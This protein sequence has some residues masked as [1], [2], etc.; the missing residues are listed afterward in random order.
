[1]TDPATDEVDL[2]ESPDSEEVLAARLSLYGA[3]VDDPQ[4]LGTFT[5]EELVGLDD[6]GRPPSAPSPWLTSLPRDEQDSAVTAAL[7][8]LTAR[9][10]YLA[11]PVDEASGT[12]V[13]RAVPEILALLTMR[14]YTGCV[15]VA[16][17]QGSEARDWVVLYE[18]RAGL[19]LAEYVSHTGL[20]DFVL[21]SGEETA[22]ALTAWSGARGDVPAP[23]VDVVLTREQVAAQAPELEPVGRCT[24]AITVT[25]L[26]LGETTTE[27]WT[28]VFTG[29][30]GSYVSAAVPD[31]GR[32]RYC[33]AA[34]D[35][36]LAHW[37]TVLGVL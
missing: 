29:H 20:H 33:G 14:R 12:F 11:S 34:Q 37:R 6:L 8:G 27:T 24:A 35:D 21:A 23:E 17:R 36:V 4:R 26:V 10:V 31:T 5:D 9:G 25:R 22:A 15:V 16:E 28:G 30:E 19:W 7:R 32:V 2:L 1:M 18:Q 3:A 13:Y